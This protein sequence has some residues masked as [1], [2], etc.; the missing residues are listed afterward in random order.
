MNHPVSAD[1]PIHELFTKRWSPRAFSD[2]A[3]AEAD[4][5]AVLEAARWA[6]SAYNEQPW[7]FLVATSEDSEAHA[8]MLAGLNEFNRSWAAAAPVL[9]VSLARSRFSQND[10]PN[11]HALHDV[12]QAVAQLALEAAV[13]GLM[14]HQ[15]AGILPQVIRD[16]Y[17]VPEGWEIVAG[18]AL[19]Y[20]GEAPQLPEGLAEMERAPRVRNP[21][22]AFVFSGAFGVAR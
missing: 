4:L 3:V 10:K 18:I 1:H 20:A 6:P 13:R 12:G 21:Q 15:M 9:L 22:R 16:T 8:A 11:A 17:D 14:I 7:A 5:R 2:R 19:G